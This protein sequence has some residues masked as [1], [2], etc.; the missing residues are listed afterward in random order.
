MQVGELGSVCDVS[1]FAVFIPWTQKNAEEGIPAS[2]KLKYFWLVKSI[3]TSLSN[4]VD[5][6]L[7]YF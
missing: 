7:Y 4:S 5:K 2:M 3:R 1:L 6:Y